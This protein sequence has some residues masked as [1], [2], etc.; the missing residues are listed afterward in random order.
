[1]LDGDILNGTHIDAVFVLLLE[2]THRQIMAMHMRTCLN[3]AG[4]KPD[5]RAVAPYR[6]PLLDIPQSNFVARWDTLGH[7]DEPFRG[8]RATQDD[9]TVEGDARYGNI[10]V[11]MQQHRHG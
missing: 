1:M 3:G 9:A 2:L 7:C 5:D 10:V 11:G 6:L 8:R 4:G